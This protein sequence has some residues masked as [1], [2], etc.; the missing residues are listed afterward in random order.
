M[1][2]CSPL[3]TSHLP[4]ALPERTGW[5]TRRDEADIEEY[6]MCAAVVVPEGVQALV[7]HTETRSVIRAGVSWKSRNY[8]R[9]VRF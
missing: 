7:G 9:V 6:M 1:T 8:W 5:P 2:A 4:Y 3:P